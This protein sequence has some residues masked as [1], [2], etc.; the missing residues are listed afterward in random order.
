MLVAASDTELY[1]VDGDDA[2]AFDLPTG[3]S[4]SLGLI[5][6]VE[7]ETYDFEGYQHENGGG[8]NYEIW[9]APGNQLDIDLADEDAFL[10]V[11]Y[12]LSNASPDI[13]RWG[14]GFELVEFVP[15]PMATTTATASWTRVTWTCR[16]SRSPAVRIRR[17]SI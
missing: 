10:S 5:E 16:R 2:L 11:F 8:A 15:P 7:G 6:L 1:N 14:G 17:S 13:F 3:N 4:N 9:A 12:P